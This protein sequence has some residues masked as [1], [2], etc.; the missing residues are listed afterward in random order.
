MAIIAYL[1]IECNLLTKFDEGAD[2]C[3]P[4]DRRICRGVI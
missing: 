2:C 4:P 3:K 1:F